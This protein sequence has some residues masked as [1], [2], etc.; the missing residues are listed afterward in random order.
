MNSAPLPRRPRVYLAGFDVFRRDAREHGARL[1]AW[2]EEYGF[3]GVYPLDAQAVLK[4]CG[5]GKMTN[6]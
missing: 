3:E 4:A 2:C 1:V 6:E 5:V